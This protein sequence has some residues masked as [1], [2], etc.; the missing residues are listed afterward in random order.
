[1]DIVNIDITELV[2]SVVVNVSPLLDTV[3][4]TVDST[5]D[6]VSLNITPVI[7]D[8]LIDALSQVDSVLIE[9]TEGSIVAADGNYDIGKDWMALI[10]GYK[11]V[12]VFNTDISFGKVYDYTY[13]TSTTDVV[14]YRYI[15]LDGSLDAFYTMFDGSN[16]AGLITEK[17]IIL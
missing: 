17:K 4:I 3:E 6:T 5:L 12:P 13:Q 15:A 9:I 1:M 2:D 8:V 7:A 11:T 14:Y 16:V 10:R